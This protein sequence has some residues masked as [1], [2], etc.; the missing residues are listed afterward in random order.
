MRRRSILAVA[1]LAFVAMF[2]STALAAKPAASFA[3]RASNAAQGGTLHI[4]ARVRHADRTSAFSASA[5]VHFASG[6][7]TVDLTRSGRSFTAR[8]EV[9]VASDAALG[10]VAVEVTIRYGMTSQVLTVQ[11]AVQPPDPD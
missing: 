8:G 2:G 1:T 4:L 3:A 7:V 11:G 5:V 10:P 9:P 6:P